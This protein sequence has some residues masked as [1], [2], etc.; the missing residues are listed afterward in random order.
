MKTTTIT[1]LAALL[2]VCGGA[3]A[4][5]SAAASQG[6]PKT[7]EPAGIPMSIE[8]HQPFDQEGT[9][10]ATGAGLCPSG[11]NTSH[12]IVTERVGGALF[13]VTKTF[14]CH[15]GSGTFDMHI[16]ASFEEGNN[17]DRGS[18]YITGGTGAY[19]NMTGSGELRGTYYPS[20]P[21]GGCGCAFEGIDDDFTGT[22]IGGPA[23]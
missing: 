15:D 2:M 7:S 13:D 5:C 22:V 10:V 8:G 18:W 20:D 9:F 23:V 19:K 12:S 16:K 6:A 17:Y 4:A 1:R 21:S 3:T 11:T 14:I